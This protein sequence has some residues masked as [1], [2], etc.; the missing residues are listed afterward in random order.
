MEGFQVRNDGSAKQLLG[1]IAGSHREAGGETSAFIL[2]VLLLTGE[3][4]KLNEDTGKGL[5]STAGITKL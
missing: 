4:L 2:Y 1:G 5:D 3:K